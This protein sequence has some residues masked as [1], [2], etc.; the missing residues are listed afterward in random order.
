M[1]KITSFSFKLLIALLL[2]A[3]LSSIGQTQSFRDRV[4]A[5]IRDSVSESGSSSY[6][7]Y[8]ALLSQSGTDAP[9]ATVLQNTL[10]G[11]VVWARVS[12]GY[13]T[14]TLAGAFPTGRTICFLT[15]GYLLGFLVGT[16]DSSPNVISVSSYVGGTPT[17]GQMGDASI[18]IRLYPE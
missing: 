17:D 9:V 2:F 15:N 4:G 18:E 7:V 1:K 16:V 5:V 11:T 6:L 8:T 13:Y 14:G 3:P 10:G 12:D